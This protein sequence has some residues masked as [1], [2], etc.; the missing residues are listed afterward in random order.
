MG[1]LRYE[2]GRYRVAKQAYNWAMVTEPDSGFVLQRRQGCG[3]EDGDRIIPI[4]RVPSPFLWSI[5]RDVNNKEVLEIKCA[6]ER[7]ER[8]RWQFLLCHWQIEFRALMV[9]TRQ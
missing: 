5:G 9:R 4:E 2:R 8:T 7:R 6:G 1:A 3:T